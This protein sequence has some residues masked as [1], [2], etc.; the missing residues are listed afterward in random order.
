MKRNLKETG[1]E[2]IYVIHA[3]SGYE[4][5]EE[6]INRLFPEMGMKHEFMTD[7]DISN[8]TPELL[9]KY[10]TPE[11]SSVLSKG[12][13]SCTLN[14]ILSYEKIVEN[15]N[16]FA[17]VFENDPFFLGDFN[18][19]ITAVVKEAESLEPGFII[20]LENSTLRF[21]LY[22]T[23]RKDKL[24]YEATDGRCA[25]AYL[26]DY[27]AAEM[28]LKDLKTTKCSRVIDWW[29]NSMIDRNVIRIYWAHPALTEQGSH[30]G[31][32]S[33]PLSTNK[34]NL[35]RRIK[36]VSQKFYKTHLLRYFK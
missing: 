24:I 28:I 17:L 8:F 30:N 26:M 12:A 15:R 2:G 34:K 18:P 19:A 25:G 22:K 29:H 32:M 1:I 31:L 33:C 6:R 27:R 20:S 23:T 5:H 9:G 3:K 21:P 4:L 7:G 10:F 11:I 36:W 16:R 35:A 13:L 14:H